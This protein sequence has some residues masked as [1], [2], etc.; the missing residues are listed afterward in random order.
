MCVRSVRAAVA[1]RRGV[2]LVGFP[3]AVPAAHTVWVW[4]GFP[5]GSFTVARATPGGRAADNL[6]D[7]CGEVT[8]GVEIA[9][10][11][12]PALAAAECA[13]GQAQFGFHR[14]WGTTCPRCAA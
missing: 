9:V 1:L 7:E 6:A 14:A 13:F 10:Q 8:G 2:D 3:V 11:R 12:E 5:S 4:C